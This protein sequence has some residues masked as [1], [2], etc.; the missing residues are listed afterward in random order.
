MK[1]TQKQIEEGSRIINEFM[2][3]YYDGSSDL[4][5]IRGE[6]W[7]EGKGKWDNHLLRLDHI[8]N[9]PRFDLDTHEPVPPKFH[10]SFDWLVPVINKLLTLGF[11]YV[12]GNEHPY[13]AGNEFPRVVELIELY[14][15][16]NLKTK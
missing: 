1:L 6:E 2:G 8:M 15:K 5:C 10:T 12:M 14:Y 3:V 11:N 7:E 16:N 13:D 9:S 4:M